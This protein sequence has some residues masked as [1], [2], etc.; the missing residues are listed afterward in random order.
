LITRPYVSID[1]GP[2]VGGMV[3]LI[4]FLS[5]LLYNVLLS[6]KWDVAFYRN[7]PVLLCRVSLSC[8][9]MCSDDQGIY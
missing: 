7:A 3:Y 9:S 1:I 8:G 2:G 6:D 4:F 5:V